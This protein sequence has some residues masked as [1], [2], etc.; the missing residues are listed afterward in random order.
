MRA[1]GRYILAGRIQAIGVVSTLTI[2]SW[3]LPPLTYLLSAVP[4]S[5]ITLRR[6]PSTGM[7]VIL[8]TF[9]VTGLIAQI[10]SLGP[11]I[12][13]AFAL[14]IWAPSWLC[15]I[16]LRVTESQ[17][18]LVM[19][20]GVIGMLVVG[21]MHAFVS[22]VS[23][24][25][26]KSFENWINTAFPPDIAGDYEKLLQPAVQYLNA[27]MGSALVI[28]LILTVLIARWWQSSL[29]MPGGFRT[30]FHALRL[31]RT[32]VF[33]TLLAVGLLYVDTGPVEPV[34]RDMVIVVLFLY[35]FQGVATIHRAVFGHHLSRV[36]LV[37]MYGLLF[38]L[39]QTVLF[40]ACVGM[41][42]S[43][44]DAGRPGPDKE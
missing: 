6:G 17:G 35:L 14:A 36:W 21:S 44:I 34:I 4:V 2:I 7:Q 9:L 12:A 13:V 23:A 3:F 15:A 8:G 22:D 29:F 1:L 19:V 38:L 33:P 24:W 37:G 5:L 43:I 40:L 20:A 42:D 41:A 10:G 26:Q 11:S 30:E 16:V 32:L 31:P 28:S 25:W 18:L 27:M 39:P